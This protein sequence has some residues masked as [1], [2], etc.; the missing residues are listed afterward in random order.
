MLNVHDYLS[1]FK[2]LECH[3][4]FFILLKYILF[5]IVFDKLSQ[6]TNIIV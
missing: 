2:K 3:Y 1:S 5:E 4:Y 6:N